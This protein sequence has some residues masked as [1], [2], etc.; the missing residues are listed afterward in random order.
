MKTAIS[1]P[2]PVFRSVE[3]LV[4]QAGQSRSA[5]YS[6][7]LREFVARHSDEEVTDAMNAAVKD[8]GAQ[9]DEFPSRAARRVLAGTEW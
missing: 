7:A 1:I 8:I 9:R 3:R 5:V 2:D 4:R 6:R